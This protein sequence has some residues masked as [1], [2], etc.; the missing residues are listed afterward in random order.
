MVYFTIH[1]SIFTYGCVIN[2]HWIF[3][4]NIH[5]SLGIFSFSVFRWFSHPRFGCL[6][7]AS[8]LVD[9]SIVVLPSFT[10]SPL[11]RPVPSSPTPVSF[12][13]PSYS[14]VS[15]LLCITC[16]TTI[17]LLNWYSKSLGDPESFTYAFRHNKLNSF[18][19]VAYQSTEISERG[20][21]KFPL[22]LCRTCIKVLDQWL[23]CLCSAAYFALLFSQLFFSI[24]SW[25]GLVVLYFFLWADKGKKNRLCLPVVLP[26]CINVFS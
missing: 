2:F 11:T 12:I 18:H 15:G 13:W 21:Q 9:Y 14:S 23:Y 16:L 3:I 22:L 10:W 4:I 25:L 20:G 17:F 7:R 24:A 5:I 26:F 8:F 19:V 1:L 6:D